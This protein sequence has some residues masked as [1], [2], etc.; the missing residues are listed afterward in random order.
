[1]VVVMVENLGSG[2]GSSSNGDGGCS[3]RGCGHGSSSVAVGGI[4]GYNSGIEDGGDNGR[5]RY[6]EQNDTF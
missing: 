5:G 1:M 3:S 2:Y 4:G 6:L